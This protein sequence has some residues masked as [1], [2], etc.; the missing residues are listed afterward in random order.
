MYVYASIIETFFFLAEGFNIKQILN[1]KTCV[2]ILFA[3]KQP[4][5]I[6]TTLAPPYQTSIR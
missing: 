6:K 1:W 5:A 2:P 3:G 4:A